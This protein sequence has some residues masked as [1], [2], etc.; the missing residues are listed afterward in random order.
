MLAM[1]VN[2]EHKN[3]DAILLYVTFACNTEIQEATQMASFEL[4]YGRSPA[5]TLDTM[6]PNVTDEEKTLTS[7]ST[8]KAPKKPDNSPFVHQVTAT[9]QQPLLRSMTPCRMPAQRLCLGADGD[10]AMWTQ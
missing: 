1:Y 8:F 3:W 5:T 7:P 10:T 4:V 6:I 2:H 9:D